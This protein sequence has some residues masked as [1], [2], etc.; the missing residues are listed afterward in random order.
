MNILTDIILY[1]IVYL[2]YSICLLHTGALLR[3]TFFY[4][5]RKNVATPL[6]VAF[7]PYSK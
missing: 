7:L 1:S 4:R 3:H 2:S 5:T 6:K